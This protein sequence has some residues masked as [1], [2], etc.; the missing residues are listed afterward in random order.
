MF[1]EEIYRRNKFIHRDNNSDDGSQG[2]SASK[3]TFNSVYDLTDSD[4]SVLAMDVYSLSSSE[5]QIDINS[6][7][8]DLE[9]MSD[10]ADSDA[11]EDELP[12]LEAIL[13]TDLNNGII[14][15]R[16]DACTHTEEMTV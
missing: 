3:G 12:S 4:G 6:V 2:A 1:L 11:N 14:I 16:N 9:S 7:L 8:P 15:D 13:D 5:L 10:S